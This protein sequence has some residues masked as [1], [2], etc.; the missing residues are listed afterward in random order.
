MPAEVML[1]AVGTATGVPY[2][3]SWTPE[4]SSPLNYA[5]TLGMPY[6]LELFGRGIRK[7]TC[8]NCERSDE[9]SLNQ[10]LYLLTDTDVLSRTNI[11]G[12]RL[13]ALK[14]VADDRTIVEELYLAT[15]SRY[16][17]RAEMDEA[18][19]Y[20]RECES[21]EAWMEDVLWSLLNVREFVFKR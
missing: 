2:R 5:N 12:G 19:K 21:R 13:A 9:P 16:P 4:G 18:V 8:G 7:Q 3:F 6:P 11:Q 20:R 1:H 10:A 14:A 15:L 17:S